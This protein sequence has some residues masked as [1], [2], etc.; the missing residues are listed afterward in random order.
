MKRALLMVAMTAALSGQTA[1]TATTRLYGSYSEATPTGAAVVVTI[2]QPSTGARQLVF[3][4][5]TIFCSVPCVPALEMNGTAATATPAGVIKLDTRA[6]SA[7]AGVFTGSDVGAGTVIN[8][9]PIAAG[10]QTDILKSGLT[11][12]VSTG[13]RQNLTIRTDAISG[14]VRILLMWSEPQ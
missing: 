1:P 11:L 3:E 6:P 13:V 9:Y 12:G 5:G 10:G 2:Q 7:T 4:G 14:T 8:R